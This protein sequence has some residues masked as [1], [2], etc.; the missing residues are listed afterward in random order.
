M[1]NRWRR[2][3]VLL[4]LQFNDGRDVPDEWLADAVIEVVNHFGAASYETQRVEGHWR[5]ANVLYRDNL[6][7]LI[8]D[9][10]DTAANRKWMK[11]FKARWKK[12]LEQLELWLVSY[13]ITVE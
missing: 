11:A 13:L 1:P 9:V 6:V 5:H 3:E 10:P 7:R 12:K 2:Y 4:P 8:V